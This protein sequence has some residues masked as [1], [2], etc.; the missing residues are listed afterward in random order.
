[1]IVFKKYY[2][3]EI[4][5]SKRTKKN[6]KTPTEIGLA[7]FI[8]QPIHAILFGGKIRLSSLLK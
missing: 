1:M 3:N 2:F 8:V 6:N 4:T 5:F 7:K